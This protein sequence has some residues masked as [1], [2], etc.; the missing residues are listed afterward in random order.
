MTGAICIVGAFM[1]VSGY[2]VA[3]KIDWKAPADKDRLI[4]A[5]TTPS[6]K[7]DTWEPLSLMLN[8]GYGKPYDDTVRILED[9][10]KGLPP[11]SD[12]ELAKFKDKVRGELV[13]VKGGQF[14]MGDFGPQ[15]SREKLPYSA[16]NGAAPAHSV[17]L[18]SYS[19]LRHRIT[20][21]DFDLYTRASHLPPIGIP[22]AYELQ[23]RF[24]DF[25][26][27]FV[28]WQQSRD[29][30][31]WAGEVTGMPLDLPTEA[32]WEYAARSRGEMWVIPST[33]VPVVDGK[34]NLTQMD[35]LITAKGEGTS[36]EPI[37]S[38]PVGTYGENRLGM[39]DVF[40]YGREWTYDWFDPNY[41]SHSPKRN[42][43]GP[44]A[45]TLRSVRYG[46]DSR[47]HLVIDRI[48][49]APD[50]AKAGLGF[51]CALN[52]AEPVRQ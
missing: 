25:P 9:Y 45:G 15:F 27:S 46:T 14:L 42:P 36:P 48:G 13:S 49:F 44:S 22:N 10:L 7:R 43:R 19:V 4:S 3:Q 1:M 5:I 39:S 35:D 12:E 17:D 23:F 29:F 28:T 34:Y 47:I 50:T 32:Q 24:P 31:K 6:P 21:A 38:R 11:P 52:Q 2:A 20:F 51:R 40:G 8:W 30:C 18:D 37:I 33:E 41:Y 16:N 26:A